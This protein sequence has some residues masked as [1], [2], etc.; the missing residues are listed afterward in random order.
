MQT[1]TPTHPMERKCSACNRPGS[2][3]GMTGPKAKTQAM[4][5]WDMFRPH[6]ARTG[7]QLIGKSKSPSF[8]AEDVAMVRAALGEFV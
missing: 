8:T 4:Y 2:W 7:G 5:C 6:G 1:M 3:H